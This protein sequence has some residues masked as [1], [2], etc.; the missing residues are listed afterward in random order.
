MPDFHTPQTSEAQLA[1]LLGELL[2]RDGA[3]GANG[4]ATG[5]VP[6][7]IIELRDLAR[8]LRAASQSVPLPEGRLA[9]RRALLATVRRSRPEVILARAAW[10]RT[11]WWLGIVA[12]VGMIVAAFGPG[13]GLLTGIGSRSS[14]LQVWQLAGDRARV[15][16]APGHTKG[17]PS[18]ATPVQAQRARINEIALSGYSRP[19]GV[20]EYRLTYSF[21]GV[22]FPSTSGEELTA[23]GRIGG[24]PVTLALTAA[25]GCPTGTTCGTFE[26]WVTPLQGTLASAEFGQIRGT[27]M[28][29][30]GKCSLSL[31][32]QTG[33]FTKISASVLPADAVWTAAGLI[34]T[35]FA[36]PGDWVALVDQTATTLESEGLLPSGVTVT[37]LVSEAATNQ[38]HP[39][40]SPEG[41]SDETVS[42]G[43]GGRVSRSEAAEE[44][45]SG[46]ANASDGSAKG[47][48]KAGGSAGATASTSGG[49]ASGSATGSVSAGT[50]S[51][52]NGGSG[53]ASGSTTTAGD[54]TSGRGSV[55][56]G[57]GSGGGLGVG[58]GPNAHGGGVAGGGGHGAEGLGAGLP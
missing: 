53:S 29:T 57:T 26:A 40:Q 54:S 36:S 28:C 21:A 3:K 30:A 27:F 42:G 50:D 33:V 23:A 34:E 5:D 10:R 20:A 39:K 9:V 56:G 2:E 17:T 8:L 52:S 41:R 13:A 25:A 37:D 46:T 22:R 24:L 32:S 35:A 58:G 31:M 47:D 45:M 12:T 7:E 49:S 15:A 1:G 14:P 6:P 55:S 48:T 38:S 11:G 43:A 44:R 4:F 16:S 51:G 18:P 19:A